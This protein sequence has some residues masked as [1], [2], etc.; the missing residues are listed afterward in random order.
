MRIVATTLW[1]VCVV[2][3]A[4]AADDIAA[5]RKLH[6]AKCARCH[7]LYDPTGYNQKTW[8]TWTERMKQK[9][10]LN[11]EQYRQLVAY[12]NSIREGVN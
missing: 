3:L 8:D 7:K 11:D 4:V 10:R 12:L 2:S 5:G 6:T 9:A 1:F